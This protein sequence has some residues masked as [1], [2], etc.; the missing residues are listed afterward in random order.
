MHDRRYRRAMHAAEGYAEAGGARVDVRERLR[1]WVRANARRV[2][3]TQ[4]SYYLHANNAVDILDHAHKESLLPATEIDDLR[5]RV[6]SFLREQM[7]TYFAR[8]EQPAPE[9][10]HHPFALTALT[11]ILHQAERIGVPT[12]ATWRELPLRWDAMRQYC[13]DIANDD[14]LGRSGRLW[15]AVQ[16]FRLSGAAMPEVEQAFAQIVPDEHTH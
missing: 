11:A 5:S 10:P 9:D 7:T 15:Q 12:A 8:T 13:A 14:F 2:V 16:N 1:A 4:M 3:E 6:A